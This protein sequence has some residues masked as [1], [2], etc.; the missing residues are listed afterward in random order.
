MARNEKL[1]RIEQWKKLRLENIE[2]SFE[3]ERQ[4][5]FDEYEVGGVTFTF[6]LSS[7]YLLIIM[8]RWRRKGCKN[9]Y[10]ITYRTN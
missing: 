6:A 9:S 3:A 8:R 2:K 7:D 4:Q 1:W 10:C 5:A